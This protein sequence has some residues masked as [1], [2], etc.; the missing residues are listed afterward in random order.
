MVASSLS[1]SSQVGSGRRIRSLARS[2]MCSA[3]DS[4]STTFI[5]TTPSLPPPSLRAR[6]GLD[7][8][9]DRCSLF[10]RDRGRALGYTRSQPESGDPMARDGAVYACQ[11]CG[12]VQTKWQGQCPGCGAWN[13][14]V[15]E[16]TS[17]P[18]GAMAPSKT[19]RGRGLAF[20]GLSDATLAPPRIKTGVEEFDRVCGRGVV[21]GSAILLG[22][23][24]GVGKSTLLLQVAA[25]A[26]RNGAACAYISGEE[27]IE[28]VRSRAQRMG[29]S[30]APV[31]L[32]AETSLREILEGLKRDVFDLVVIDSIQ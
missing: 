13:T 7:S 1:I 28:Q 22:G 20:E 21:P 5:A 15:E 27:A 10:V 11:S 6:H 30:D 25:N 32:A 14:L 23:D 2:R 8:P 31:R 24:P 17:R 4:G 9:G 18:P 12:S 29:L 16:L 3:R 19:T 26:A